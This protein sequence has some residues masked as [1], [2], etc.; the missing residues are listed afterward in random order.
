MD[1]IITKIEEFAFSKKV[2][3]AYFVPRN[4]QYYNTLPKPQQNHSQ[5]VS[6]FQ[7]TK[8]TARKC[9]HIEQQ[10]IQYAKYVLF[11]RATFH[12]KIHFFS[13][14]LKSL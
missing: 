14:Y 10:Y 9:L 1:G 11:L 4:N 13:L 5:V 3:L 7:S 6:Q 2:N 8:P 12:L